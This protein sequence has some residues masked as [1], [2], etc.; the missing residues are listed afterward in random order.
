MLSMMS[1]EEREKSQRITEML[2]AAV[3]ADEL[4]RPELADQFRADADREER[5][6]FGRWS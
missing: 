6:S 3:V 1:A 4:G 5:E 2:D